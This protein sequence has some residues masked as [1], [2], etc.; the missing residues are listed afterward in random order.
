MLPTSSPATPERVWT[1]TLGPVQLTESVDFPLARRAGM[2]G[3]IL[4]ATSGRHLSGAVAQP[5]QGTPPG[6]RAAHGCC[7][8]SH[9][10]WLSVLT[11]PGPLGRAPVT[12]HLV[13][14]P[15]PLA[16]FCVV[17]AGRGV[18]PIPSMCTHGLPLGPRPTCPSTDL[19]GAAHSPSSPLSWAPTQLHASG[20][21]Y[22]PLCCSEASS[23]WS[24]HTWAP[25]P[26][27]PTPA[28]ACPHPGHPF[29]P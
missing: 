20:H 10:T 11:P 21:L 6:S 9:D 7:Q 17:P 23:P 18:T 22:L 24:S 1:V 3:D 27:A 14:A 29:N 2:L 19:V 15:S 8:G 28:M 26:A 13:T 5:A 25:P 4:P 16:P 12:S